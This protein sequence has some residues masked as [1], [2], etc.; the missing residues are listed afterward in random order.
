MSFG[1]PN[2]ACQLWRRVRASRL[3]PIA[4]GGYRVP[5]AIRWP[6]VIKPG[7]VLNDVFAHEDMLPTLL[8]AAGDTDVK[9]K[10]LKGMKVGNKTFKVHLDR[11]GSARRVLGNRARAVGHGGGQPAH[12][13]S[14][15]ADQRL[16]GR[17]ELSR[18]WP[19]GLR[20]AEG[21]RTAPAARA[22]DPRRRD[23]GGTFTIE[24]RGIAGRGHALSY[25][26][27]DGVV[28]P[29]DA[30]PKPREAEPVA[31]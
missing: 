20:L 23:V 18:L 31:R 5:T 24:C 11:G 14:R 16:S 12:L 28:L 2:S 13:G 6:G 1:S 26:T 10:L 21:V 19:G 15:R 7:T 4:G 25:R 17:V 8:A 3:I 9:Q 27:E 29:A 22:E 30:P